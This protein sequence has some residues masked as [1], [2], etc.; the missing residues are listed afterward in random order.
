MV[1]ATIQ[2]APINQTSDR[3]RTP[4][5]VNGDH[6]T[7]AEFERRYTAMVDVKKAELIEGMVIMP[8]PVSNTHGKA[9]SL[10]VWW[11]VGYAAAT[12]GAEVGENTTVRLDL[13]NEVQPDAHLR[14]LESAGGAS[15]VGAAGYIDGAPEL[16]VEIAI[17][18]ASYD[19]HVKRRIYRRNGVRE[20]LIWR[21]EDGAIEWFTLENGDYVPLVADTTGVIRSRVFPGLWLAADALLAGDLA[22]VL[23]ALQAGLASPEH[24]DFVV[25]LTAGK[26]TSLSQ[27][28]ADG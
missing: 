28:A 6:L 22:A 11:L 4:R 19:Y 16:I 15:H 13:D 18:S 17:S 10:I 25:R 23:A 8:S 14:L 27:T 20:Y 2:A 12:P 9:N 5:L 3:Q 26:P 24:A 21:V 7:R 1:A